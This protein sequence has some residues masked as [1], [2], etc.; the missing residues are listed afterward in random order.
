MLKVSQY[1]CDL[2]SKRY[3]DCMLPKSH[4]LLDIK[5]LVNFSFVT[6]EVKDLY[7]DTGR[8]SIDP[9]RMFKMLF[10]MFFSNIPSERDLVEQ[11]Q[12]NVLYRYF[13]DINLDEAI[14]DHSTFTVFRQRLGKERFKRL[15]NRVL[16]QCI[17]YDLVDGSHVSFD[18]TIVRADCAN[19]HDK[20][21]KGDVLNDAGRIIDKVFDDTPTQKTSRGNRELPLSKSDPDARWTRKP[22]EG[23]VIGYNAH[24]STDSKEKIIT[25]VDVT[26]ANIPGHEKMIDL[27][28]EQ[29][30]EHDL[31][32]KEV[33]ADTEYG[34][35]HV[36]RDLEERSITGYIPLLK[37]RG[38][39]NRLDMFGYED[40]TYDKER[41]TVRRVISRMGTRS[42]SILPHRSQSLYGFT[43]IELLV[44]LVIIGLLL[45]I[46][47]PAVRG[48]RDAAKTATCANN[49]RQIYL[50]AVMY[51]D[52][53][54]GKLYFEWTFAPGDTSRVSRV[55][56][57]MTY[58]DGFGNLYDQYLDD[59]NV[60][61]CPAQR[62]SKRQET[63]S[64]FKQPGE[65]CHCDYY[66]VCYNGIFRIEDLSAKEI[67]YESDDDHRNYPHRGLGHI[68]RG[69]G[70]ISL[71][72]H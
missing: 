21:T 19:P 72:H 10:L 15:F 4:I 48:V 52:D 6:E 30:K 64:N 35:G 59:L 22:K 36:R 1:N 44:V 49:L 28:D 46:L 23:S 39:K 13:C 58:I 14:P 41:D 33:S 37:D 71:L 31:K 5:K 27:I 11:V 8:G 9:T 51:A 67:A 70:S 66:A 16:E 29:I 25:N 17:Q 62:A 3:L 69:D 56:W 24:I 61:Y 45:A 38:N 42:S 57:Q 53:H 63:L 60:F 50:A 54:D 65:I 7:S 34:A 68:V 32:I 43:L 55:L 20:R 2:F 26:P 40:F 12:V 47:L 18:A